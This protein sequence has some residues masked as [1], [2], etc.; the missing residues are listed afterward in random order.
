MSRWYFSGLALLA[1][2]AVPAIG[3]DFHWIPVS[4]QNPS[5]FYSVSSTDKANNTV[6]VA[7][8]FMRRASNPGTPNGSGSMRTEMIL[9]GHNGYEDTHQ[10]VKGDFHPSP[11]SFQVFDFKNPGVMEVISHA[12]CPKT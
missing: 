10:D 7:V 3:Q 2:L 6:S 5:V 4:P 11:A 1:V 12:V 8:A 9:C